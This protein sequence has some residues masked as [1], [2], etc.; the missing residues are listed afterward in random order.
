MTRLARSLGVRPGEGRLV[1]LVAAIFATIEVARGFGEVAAD[2]LVIGR[3]G[4]A[5]LPWL[6]I[7]LG[8]TSLVAS[9]AY[10]AAL[11]RVRRGPLLVVV[12]VVLVVLVGIGQ[13]ALVAGAAI[14]PLVWLTVY[15]AGT[16]AGT[17][18]WTLAGSVLDARQAKRLF[19]VLTSAAIIG[20]FVGTLGAGPAARI[21]GTEW[22]VALEAIGLAAAAVLVARLSADPGSGR[23]RATPP[24][25]AVV[26]ELRAGFDFVVR[27]PLMRLV[28]VAYVLFSVLAFS[29]TSPFFRAMS[30][31]FPPGASAELTT[32]LGL[33]SAAVTGTSF[34]VSLVIAPRVYARFGVASVA[35]V[36]PLVYLAGF[37]LWILAFTPPTAALVRYAQQVTQR[38]LS[39]AAWS[40]FYN[41]VPAD[42]RPQVLAFND[43]VPGQLGIILS[44]LLLLAVQT[45]LAPEQIP[46]LGVVA[47]IACTVVVLGIRRGY[48]DSLVRALRAGLGEQVLE[49]GP[50]LAA[51][52][53]DGQATAALVKALDAPEPAVRRMAAELLGRF[54]V[55]D[56]S[57]AIA[58]RATDPDPTVR[59]AAIRAV[60]LLDGTAT[61]SLIEGA[62]D[63]P[64]PAVRAAAV[65]AAATVA[66]AAVARSAQRL[67]ADPDPDVRAALAVALAMTG[68]ADR[69]AALIGDL[70]SSA[71]AEARVAGIRALARVDGT[72]GPAADRPDP[73][74]A[75]LDDDAATVRR[76]AAVALHARPS[77]PPAVLA[78]LDDGTP[79]SQDAALWALRGHA[80]AA[81][82]PVLRWAEG[83]AAR[84]A[85]LGG[86][87]RALDGASAGTPSLAFLTLLLDRR[88][89]EIVRRL[90]S[91]LA[92]LG[93]PAAGGLIRRCLGSDD[94]DV[95][96]QAIEALDSI[97]DP[98]LRRAIV[99]LIDA[100]AAGTG[101]DEEAVLRELA[102]DDDPWIRA[103]ALRARAER[104][105]AEWSTIRKHAESDPDPIVRGALDRVG[106][107]GEPT[108]PDPA[109]TLSDIDRML[110]LRRVPLFAGL[111]PEDL[112]RIAT[113][114]V[115]RLYGPDEIVVREGELGD[116][117]VVIVEGAVRVVHL[118]P[119][120]TEQRLRRYDAGDHFG[121]LAVLREAP[122]AATVIAEP[123]GV[124]GLAI[125]GSGLTAILRERP[126]AAMAMLATLA[127]R[128]SEG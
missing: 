49:G 34:F 52:A 8:L 103:L 12:L 50:G 3:F 114:A 120:G 73:L 99:G 29:V 47:A 25:R 59:A 94:P 10:G 107:G 1:A 37:G 89:D 98:S 110:F 43:G 101:P 72:V 70:V 62:L 21:V 58:A 61:A 92:V 20:S 17:L 13:L 112:Q 42:R 7:G 14:V 100:P 83:R 108:M 75:A 48:A 35:V 125:G 51:L 113:T 78:I 63:D 64:G 5:S 28:A 82:G 124:R 26:A 18:V 117:L 44:G 87:L 31:A 23:L 53:A 116:E 36:L 4:A 76:A 105:S 27:S 119:D 102:D 84:A 127:T 6:F 67:T 77:P 68:E 81:R 106:N 128:I 2:A 86:R 85:E 32:V 90:L 24:R 19:P 46:W 74:V 96:A 38:G 88:R 9:L 126:E 41:V 16:V 55:R 93:A 115:E 97:G 60:A 30:E 122:R 40:A 91:G 39:N 57:R 65:E 104:L 54:R 118:E 95:R 71:D 69:S 111:V 79:R 66:P 33:L 22:V 56:A 45:V 123:P 121:E 11:G 109:S 80:D 15:A